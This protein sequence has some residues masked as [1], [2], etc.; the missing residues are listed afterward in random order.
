MFV[1]D[2][3]VFASVGAEFVVNAVG[4]VIDVLVAVVEGEGIQELAMTFV[5]GSVVTDGMVA[6]IDLV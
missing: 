4:D 1:I 5:S 2:G 3:S 6:I